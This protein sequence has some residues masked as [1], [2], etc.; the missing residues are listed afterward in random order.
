MGYSR[1]NLSINYNDKHCFP[2]SFTVKML[3]RTLVL[4]LVAARILQEL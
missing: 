3:L 4:L 2:L 1:K